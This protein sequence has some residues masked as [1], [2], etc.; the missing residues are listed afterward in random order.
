MKF[1]FQS[2]HSE[3]LVHCRCSI[4]ML[5]SVHLWAFTNALLVAQRKPVIKEFLWANA[6]WCGLSLQHIQVRPEVSSKRSLFEASGLFPLLSSSSSVLLPSAYNWKYIYCSARGQTSPWRCEWGCGWGVWL[7]LSTHQLTYTLKVF[8][9]FQPAFVYLSLTYDTSF[10][11]AGL[12]F[13]ILPFVLALL[14]LLSFVSFLIILIRRV[15]GLFQMQMGLQ[16]CCSFF[17]PKRSSLKESAI[18]FYFPLS[19]HKM[20]KKQKREEKN[21]KKFCIV[22]FLNL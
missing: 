11:F 10:S 20:K 12:S 2:F 18:I 21:C 3:I 15:Q 5:E 9:F 13:G 19:E 1:R 17:T 6:C 7:L 4:K 16:D 14:S 8:F 22:F